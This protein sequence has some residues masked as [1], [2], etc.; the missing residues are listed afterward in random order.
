MNGGSGMGLGAGGGVSGGGS[1]GQYM[2]EDDFEDYKPSL[3]HLS[4]S[5]SYY[6][7]GSLF[8]F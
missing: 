2:S 3:A 5:L 4:S 6:S 8:L 1:G 7:S